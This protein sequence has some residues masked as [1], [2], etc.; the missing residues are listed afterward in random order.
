[1]KKICPGFT[2]IE[3]LLVISIT[4]ILFSLGVS[5][6]MKFNRQQMLSQSAQE[7]KNNLR[8]AQSKAMAG[9]KP[10]GCG[11]QSLEGYKLVF[12]DDQNYKIVAVCNADID[13]RTG[14]SLR[15]NVVKISGPDQIRFKVLA[16]GVIDFG[17]IVLQYSDIG[18]TEPVTVT[19]AGE[20]R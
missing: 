13:V 11:N 19:E 4:G 6:Y 9:E 16:Q 7:L 18:N 3:L 8:Y 2:L 17:T 15:K 20:I 5:Q 14:L 1:M 12:P 10:E